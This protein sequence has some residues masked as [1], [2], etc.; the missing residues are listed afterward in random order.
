MLADAAGGVVWLLSMFWAVICANVLAI[1]A[2]GATFT[3]FRYSRYTVVCAVAPLA[4]GFLFS[5][6]LIAN[7]P[8][9]ASIAYLPCFAPLPIGAV[10]F[11][12]SFSVKK[13]PQC[14]GTL[15][16]FLQ[17]GFPSESACQHCGAVL[18][19]SHAHQVLLA[20]GTVVSL[21]FIAQG[22]A[23]MSSLAARLCVS[24]TAMLC[25]WCLVPGPAPRK[26]SDAA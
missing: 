20:F 25:A 22:G 23:L 14:N 13:C 18:T 11:F 2:L 3:R 26:A 4:A 24:T 17:I 9:F 15:R 19:P 8:T 5:G 1:T 10:G 12:R 21:L 6:F 16:V 7:E